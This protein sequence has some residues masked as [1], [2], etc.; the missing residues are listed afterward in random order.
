MIYSFKINEED[1]RFIETLGI[2]NEQILKEAKVPYRAVQNGNYNLTEKQYMDLY[3]A[4][5]NHICDDQVLVFANIEHRDLFIPPIFA[6]LCADNGLNC[7]R[8]MSKYKQLVGP[9]KFELLEGENETAVRT[10][11]KNGEEMPS[12]ALLAEQVTLISMLRRGTGMKDLEPKKV[13]TPYRYSKP[14]VDYFGHEPIQDVLNEVVFRNEDLKIPFITTNNNMWAYLEDEMNRKIEAMEEGGSFE[15]SVRKVLFEII[16][17]GVSD[18]EKVAMELGVSKRTLQRKLKEANTTFAEQL[19]RTR[20]LLV[21]NY[22][23]M[24]MPLDEIAF[25]VNY[26]DAKSLSR[27]FKG[28]AG[29]SVSEYKKQIRC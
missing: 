14:V 7:L 13:K 5:D 17:S 1:I 4:M 18:A 24:G 16:P 19:N 20:E 9:F 2:N 10:Y 27:A 3:K 28:W 6:G 15:A 22:L 11:Y 8:R 21:R 25:L 23:K 12:F 29:I 26:S